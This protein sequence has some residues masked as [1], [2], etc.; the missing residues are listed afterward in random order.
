MTPA[1]P[2]GIL[3]ATMTICALALALAFAAAGPGWSEI[4]PGDV[5]VIRVHNYSELDVEVPVPP[6]GKILYPSVGELVLAGRTIPEVCEELR[7]RLKEASHISKP[8]VTAFI[9]S[10]AA[11]KLY[12]YGAIKAPQEIVMPAEAELTL[13]RA[14][15]IAG[16]LLPDA[17]ARSV[18]ITR[19]SPPGVLRVDLQEVSASEDPLED[20]VLEPG[21]VIYVLEREKVYILGQVSKPGAY[22]LPSGK[23]LTVSKAVSLAGGFT[24]FARYT[25]VRVTRRTE[26]GVKSFTVDVKEVMAKGAVEKDLELRSGDLVFVPERIF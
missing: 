2:T 26:E 23:V 21:D 18:K 5:V 12:I 20:V 1:P 8:I 9:R 7:T 4:A 24:K 16:G 6:G 17:D 15:A 25:R 19:G 11:E 22:S 13:S 14:V 3:H 10:R